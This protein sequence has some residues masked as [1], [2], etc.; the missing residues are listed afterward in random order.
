MCTHSYISAHIA[1]L[2]GLR[3]GP[4]G[5]A[6]PTFLLRSLPAFPIRASLKGV[7][8]VTALSDWDASSLGSIP[9]TCHSSFLLGTNDHCAW[10]KLNKRVVGG[11]VSDQGA[12]LHVVAGTSLGDSG[13]P[14]SGFLQCWEPGLFGF[15]SLL[16]FIMAK[17]RMMGTADIS[18]GNIRQCQSPAPVL[19]P[20]GMSRDGAQRALNEKAITRCEIGA[21]TS[22]RLPA[23]AAPTALCPTLSAALFTSTVNSF[24]YLVAH[25]DL[26]H[27]LLQ[28][29]R[30]G[31]S[32][33]RYTC[34]APAFPPSLLDRSVSSL[35]PALA[36]LG[37]QART[38][39]GQ[40]AWGSALTTGPD[41]AA[42]G[43]ARGHSA[44]SSLPMFTGPLRRLNSREQPV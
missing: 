16:K 5:S 3:S 6:S 39:V 25:C 17:T 22:C 18:P 38:P 20:W 40:R 10:L 43:E 27:L 24:W 42:A 19:V 32:S 44:L 1:P 15:P 36:A 2:P 41:H 30:Q 11:S 23:A 28:Q 31:L 26:H 12:W 14:G 8:L 35:A 9:S 33:P 21:D 29:G 34:L 13:G 37:L 4:Q 7:A